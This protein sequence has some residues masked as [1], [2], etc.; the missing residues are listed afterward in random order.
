[1]NVFFY[2]LFM[3]EVLLAQ[4][5]LGFSGSQVGCLDGYRVCVG[6]R[7][8]LIR[9]PG[10]QVFGIVVDAETRSVEQ[11]YAEAGL[12]DYRPEEVTVALDDGTTVTAAC[13]NLRRPGRADANTDYANA[14]LE[15]ATR[16]GFPET[17]LNDLRLQ[18]NNGKD[19]R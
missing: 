2:G 7:A 19:A 15:L 8:T 10:S 5:G 12:Q 14:L 11:L 1:M 16:L 17:Y 9:Q 13:Y 6:E 3:D 4:K 18:R